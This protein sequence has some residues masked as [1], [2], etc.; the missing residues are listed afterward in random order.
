[1]GGIF[2]G[3]LCALVLLVLLDRLRAAHPPG[4]VLGL[5]CW[6]LVALTGLDGLNAFLF[7]GTLP[8][9]YSPTTAVRLLTGLCAGLGLGLL[10]LPVVASV[11]WRDP[12]DER[13]VDDPVEIVGGLALCALVGGLIL[14]G[15]GVLLWPVALAMLVAVFVAFGAANMYVLVLAGGATRRVRDSGDVGGLLLSSC[16]LV[17]LEIGALAAL[18]SWLI[19]AFGFSW[20]V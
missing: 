6:L 8:H 15:V 18:R 14:A 13:A 7:D 10:A 1:M 20:G 5:A 3:F 17:L 12:E 11:V 19:G 4:G 2:L 9:L 16:G